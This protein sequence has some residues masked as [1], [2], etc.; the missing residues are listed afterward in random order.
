M[1]LLRKISCIY[2]DERM[3]IKMDSSIVYDALQ[4]HQN[5][6]V[7]MPYMNIFMHM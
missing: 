1:L 2:S 7:Y 6:I 4:L 3:K 5:G